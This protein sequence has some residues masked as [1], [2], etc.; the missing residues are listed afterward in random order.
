MHSRNH[1]DANPHANPRASAHTLSLQP[2]YQ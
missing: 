1:L 2:F